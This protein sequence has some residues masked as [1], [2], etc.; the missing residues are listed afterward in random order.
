MYMEDLESTRSYRF[1]GTQ[2]QGTKRTTTSK[3]QQ[4]QDLG[5]RNQDLVHILMMHIYFIEDVTNVSHRSRTISYLAN[6]A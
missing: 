4:T 6:N 5:N 3:D 2:L 1:L